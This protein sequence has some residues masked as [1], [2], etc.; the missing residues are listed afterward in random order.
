MKACDFVADAGLS[1]HLGQAE[2]GTAFDYIDEGF[3]DLGA[4]VAEASGFLHP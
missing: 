3:R 2:D 1:F 4:T